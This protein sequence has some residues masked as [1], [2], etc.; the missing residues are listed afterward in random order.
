MPSPSR[1]RVTWFAACALAIASFFIGYAV[2][3]KSRVDSARAKQPPDAALRQNAVSSSSTAAARGQDAESKAA[4]PPAT[5]ATPSRATMHQQMIAALNEP[6]STERWLMLASVLQ[7]LSA[8]NWQGALQAFDDERRLYGKEHADARA[9]LVRRAGEVVGRDAIAYFLAQKDREAVTSALTG[10][11]SKRPTEALEWL[12]QQTNAGDRAQFTGA[13]IRGLAMTEPDLAISFLE[14]APSADRRKYTANLVSTLVRTA[15]LEQTQR[16]VAGMI[17]RANSGGTLSERYMTDVFRDLAEITVRRAYVAGNV[18]S[19]IAWVDQHVGQPYVNYETVRN[20]A[21]QLANHDPVQALAWLEKVNARA[22]FPAEISP[23]G[24]G[25]VLY[26]WTGK[27]GLEPVGQWLAANPN[28]VAYDRLAMYFT[29]A[30]LQRNPSLAT[31]VAAAMKD[32]AARA[33]ALTKIQQSQSRA[34][35][36][37]KK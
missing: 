23:V 18:E 29:E 1:N 30:A 14:Q 12:A 2:A 35:P 21:G 27:V 9:F 37:A 19:A 32:P 36:S 5:S 20:S 13:A 7:G 8:D 31:P 24:Y 15:G 28:H 10:W 17:D 16:L 22:T 25:T 33:A 34:R 26:A 4:A 6:I 3:S 11:A